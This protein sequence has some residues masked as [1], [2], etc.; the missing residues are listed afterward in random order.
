MSDGDKREFAYSLAR[1][2][3]PEQGPARQSLE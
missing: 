2:D 3:H 1:S